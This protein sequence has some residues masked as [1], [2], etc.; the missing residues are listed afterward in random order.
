MFVKA[1]WMTQMQS[2][3]QASITFLKKGKP[4]STRES[5]ETETWGTREQY[6]KETG[7]QQ[8]T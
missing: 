2:Q 4:K 3:R 6:T 8:G 1:D 5:R 7:L